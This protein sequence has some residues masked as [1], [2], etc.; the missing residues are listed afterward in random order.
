MCNVSIDHEALGIL[1]EK[2]GYSAAAFAKEA[3]LS[4]SYYCRIESGE[5]TLKRNPALIKRFAE[6]LNVPTSM[7]ERRAPGENVTAGAA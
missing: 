5:R 6:L 3:G 2:D 4:L 7:L 1:R